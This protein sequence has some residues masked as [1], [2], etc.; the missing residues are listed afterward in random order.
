MGTALAGP[1][2]VSE[3]PCCDNGLCRC[4]WLGRL[5]G[6][7]GGKGAGLPSAMGL[8]G[9]SCCPAGEGSLVRGELGPAHKASGLCDFLLLLE[10]EREAW[11]FLV[12]DSERLEWDPEEVESESES[13]LD[14][15]L[16]RR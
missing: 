14:P 8:S 2:G 10:L 6:A 15:P 1:P 7:G 16:R 9:A 11:R 13:E 3:L 12:G 5:W 4:P